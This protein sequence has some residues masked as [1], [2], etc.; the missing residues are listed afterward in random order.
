MARIIRNRQ[1]QSA[2]PEGCRA[3]VLEE[4]RSR[5]SKPKPT[6]QEEP[7]EEPEPE[8]P[9][10][11]EGIVALLESMD[12]KMGIV[13]AAVVD[14]QKKQQISMQ[15][16]ETIPQKVEISTRPNP[17]LRD[18]CGF[19]GPGK[20][21]PTIAQ[22][23]EGVMV[24]KPPFKPQRAM[25]PFLQVFVYGG[26]TYLGF[27]TAKAVASWMEEQMR[28]SPSPSPE[29]DPRKQ[30]ERVEVHHHHHHT[31][32]E[33]HTREVV[34][35]VDRQAVAPIDA[36]A[37]AHGVFQRMKKSP[38]T[39]RGPQGDP[40]IPGSDGIDGRDGRDGRPGRSVR[41]PRGLRGPRGRDG[42]DGRDGASGGVSA[43]RR[44][45]TAFK[46]WE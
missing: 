38:S 25:N 4:L 31:R 42:R 39:F 19:F 23:T 20:K 22:N 41:G 5:V 46:G 8:E 30:I 24:G 45:A 3:D 27:L 29:P 12:S 16:S 21:T 13:A 2:A 36:D 14:A 43:G 34:R 28:D 1:E 40:G 9:T 17:S 7:Q 18:D 26:F 35:D 33:V 15:G 10:V 11:G 44:N 32:E 37:V 6:R